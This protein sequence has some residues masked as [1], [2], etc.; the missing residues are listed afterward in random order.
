M[1]LN[2]FECFRWLCKIQRLLFLHYSMTETFSVAVKWIIRNP[3]N[4]YLMLFKSDSEDMNPNDFDI[5]WWR[6]NRWESLE[7]ALT[8][9]IKEET[10]LEIQIGKISRSRWFTKWDLHLIWIT[11]ITYC[12]K[13]QNIN[14]SH[15]H[16]WFRRKTKDE[17]LNW[18]FPS[19]LKEEFKNI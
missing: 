6:I 2:T 16:N 18:D 15:E 14:L 12:E 4:K 7:D 8:R 3:E 13:F 19:R 1:S 5:P 11:F 17:I 9:E 10:W